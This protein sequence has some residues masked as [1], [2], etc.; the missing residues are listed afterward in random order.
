MGQ[1]DPRPCAGYHDPASAGG[2]RRRAAPPRLPAHHNLVRTRPGRMRSGR[3]RPPPRHPVQ[4]RP[5]PPPGSPP[6]P[7]CPRGRQA[8]TRCPTGVRR[9]RPSLVDCRTTC[10]QPPTT[11]QCEIHNRRRRISTGADRR[12]HALTCLRFA[13]HPLPKGEG[14]HPPFGRIDWPVGRGSSSFVWVDRLAGGERDSSFVWVDRLA[15]GEREFVLRLGGS[16]GRWGEGV[17][18]SVWV[19]RLAGGERE[20]V[21]GLGGSTGR[22]G[23]GVRPRSGWIDRPVGSRNSSS[24]W[25]DRP[26]GGE[27][28][29]V[30]GL[31]GSTGLWGAGIRPPSGRIDR[32]VGSRNSSSLWE[33]RPARR[34]RSRRALRIG[35]DSQ[36]SAT[37]IAQRADEIDLFATEEAHIPR[38][39]ADGRAGP[40]PNASAADAWTGRGTAGSRLD[41]TNSGLDCGVVPDT[42]HR[43]H[44]PPLSSLRLCTTN[45]RT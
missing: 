22:W 31:G 39:Q 9:W 6:P 42:R 8:A 16:T 33:D 34:A 36:E 15:G 4:Q 20:F 24:V 28:E 19:D 18:P 30:L 17:R 35:P 10:Q 23:E 21:L 7:C 3:H 32:P 41:G 26:A 2:R 25:E 44:L 29:F 27:Q 37:R 12:S 14:I 1:T 40:D 45:C 13:W 43:Q 11:P 38:I 5:V